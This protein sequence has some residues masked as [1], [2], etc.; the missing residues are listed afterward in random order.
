MG[1]IKKRREEKLL[2]LTILTALVTLVK[3]ILEIALLILKP[4]P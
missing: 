1:R 3:V 2:T 4:K